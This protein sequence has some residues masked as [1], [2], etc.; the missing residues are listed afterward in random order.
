M[1][2]QG[3]T[4]RERIIEIGANIIHKQG[5]NNTGIK[6]ILDAA[7]V[8]KGS[9]YFHFKNKEDFGLQVVEHYGVVFR[10]TAQ[11]TLAD[12][13]VA[14]VQRIHNLLTEFRQF[15]GQ[16]G[17]SLGCPVG[18]LAQELGDLNPALRERLN[19]ALTGFVELFAEQLKEAQ[20]R[21]ELA[22]DL[23]PR[24]TARFIVSSWH[25]ALIHMKVVKNSAP[26]DIFEK[27]VFD[28][29]LAQ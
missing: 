10:A 6:E 23:D 2:K 8:P 4:T 1:A 5:F 27:M 21:G 16:Q 24:E 26:L 20:A 18:N 17:F 28:Q 7:G 13:S 3:R 11:N 22:P 9:F 15:F 14:P 29:L 25:G 12:T 19:Q